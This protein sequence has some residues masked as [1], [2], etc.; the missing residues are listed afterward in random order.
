MS[1]TKARGDA[2]VGSVMVQKLTPPSHGGPPAHNKSEDPAVLRLPQP[3]M[4]E[5][6]QG[7]FFA[8]GIII[9]RNARSCQYR[10]KMARRPEVITRPGTGAGTC[11]RIPAARCRRYCFI[12]MFKISNG[13]RRQSR[14][15]QQW[16][17]RYT[18]THR[19]VS[20][21]VDCRLVRLRTHRVAGFRRHAITAV[22][23]S[24]PRNADRPAQPP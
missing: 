14:H 4:D 20:C 22:E 23:P 11:Q 21:R 19:L 24:V 3:L 15:L 8:F 7:V 2:A 6:Q 1:A 10:R 12:R 9:A 18:A 17:A 13:R 5:A 16:P